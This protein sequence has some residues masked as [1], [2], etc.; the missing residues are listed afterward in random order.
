MAER[1]D[2][3][4]ADVFQGLAR[5]AARA[6]RV[7]AVRLEVADP[8]ADGPN[9]A[10]GVGMP[11]CRVSLA[12]FASATRGMQS[13]VLSDLAIDQGSGRGGGGLSWPDGSVRF[14]AGV[15][16]RASDGA[17]LGMLCI[18]DEQPRI[19]DAD[20]LDTLHASARQA[21]ALID[22]RRM[23]L[24]QD[25]A[26]ERQRIELEAA[27][28]FQGDLQHR[29]KNGLQTI[30]SLM[31]LQSRTEAA[32]GEKGAVGRLRERLRPL[33][34]LEDLKAEAGL[35]AVDL[36]PYLHGVVQAAADRQSKAEVEI[37][38]SLAPIVVARGKALPLGMIVNEFVSNSFVHVGQR[39]PTR[40]TITLGR[41]DDGEVSLAMADDG[42][43]FDIRAR[44]SAGVG[45][46][47]IHA[48]CRQAR[49]EPVWQG[50]N[51]TSLTLRFSA[52]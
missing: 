24:D 11:G 18:L 51:G 30:D 20:Q 39:Q 52:T 8:R 47:L 12:A 50:D 14:F 36:R 42:P 27:R 46:Q 25:Q 7:P 34:L 19:M 4:G 37:I 1:S 15:A 17:N 28:R 5:I 32:A 45:L 33:Y 10:V 49:A 13:L 31:S 6:C 44:R 26:E 22:L 41:A 40:L 38:E 3:L 23:H 29:F 35:A 2:D 16:L 21:V 48:L 43:G 9:L